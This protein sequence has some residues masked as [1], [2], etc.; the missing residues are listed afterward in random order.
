M[1]KG[2]TLIELLIVISIIGILVALSTFGLNNARQ[3]SRDT[4]R[5]TDLET[6]RAGLEQY[7]ADCDTYPLPKGGSPGSVLAVIGLSLVGDGSSTGCAATNTYISSMPTD[8]IGS[9]YY[10]YYSNGTTYRLCATQETTS[11]I[12]SGCTTGCG[13]GSVCSYRVNNP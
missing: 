8:P 7:R 4:K 1:R 13:S 10:E 5:K 6:I 9:N 2:F 3:S 11:V 12:A